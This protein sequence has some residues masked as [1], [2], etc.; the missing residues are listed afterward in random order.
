MA[1]GV[2]TGEYYL[3]I[4]LVRNEVDLLGSYAQPMSISMSPE[5]YNS[6]RQRV[7]DALNPAYAGFK[8]FAKINNILLVLFLLEI[9]G[10]VYAS[11]ASDAYATFSSVGFSA[12][13]L[14]AL[15]LLHK[16]FEKKWVDTRLPGLIVP[17]FEHYMNECG[18]N[19]LLIS[20]RTGLSRRN[21]FRI[22]ITTMPN[23]VQ[24]VNTQVA[25]AQVAP[26]QVAP[27][28][29][30]PAQ[31]APVQYMPA[32]VAP[33]A[34][35]PTQVVPAQVAPVAVAPAQVTPGQVQPV[36]AAPVQ[37]APVVDNSSVVT[38]TTTTA[39]KEESVTA[40]LLSSNPDA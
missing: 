5:Q 22:V 38:V 10:V 16:H 9:A 40:P 23:G 2:Y 19:K 27:A 20:L 28:Q 29:V 6:F 24:V 17:I 25:P 14:L 1:S 3:D 26:A 39:N 36:M 37:A 30:A 4:V 33:V 35:M 11:V 18:R 21:P 15:F 13:L 12:I 31:V 8:V 7:L 34:M 32:Q